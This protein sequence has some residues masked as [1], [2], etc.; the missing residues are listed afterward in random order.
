[1]ATLAVEV[2]RAESRGDKKANG[3]IG[4]VRSLENTGLEEG[5]VLVIP[6]DFSDVTYDQMLN[7]N[8]VQYVLCQID[9]TENV[10]AFYPSTFTKVRTV[11]NENGSRVEQGGRPVRK[12]TMGTAAELFRTFGSVEEGM[13]ALRGKKIKVTKITPVRT[14]RYGTTELMTAQIPTIDLVEA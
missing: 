12:Y 2:K 5:D 11:Y 1:M 9:G 8:K 13:N 14:L 7:G 4:A 10:K 6:T 3:F